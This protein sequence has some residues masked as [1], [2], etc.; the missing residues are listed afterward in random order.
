MLKRKTQLAKPVVISDGRFEERVKNLTNKKKLTRSEAETA[1]RT[2][3]REKEGGPVIRATADGQAY[4]EQ[5][6]IRFSVDAHD[7]NNVVGAN[8]GDNVIDKMM[9]SQVASLAIANGFPVSPFSRELLRPV[10]TGIVQLTWYRDLE[11]YTSAHLEENQ[12][13]RVQLYLDKL[14]TYKQEPEVSNDAPKRIRKANPAR[15]TRRFKASPG[16][17]KGKLDAGREQALYGVLR[18]LKESTNFADIVKA[19]EGKVETKQPLEKI[20]DRFLGKLLAK[21][22]ITAE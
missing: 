13:K 6:D 14:K 12:E 21:G 17:D 10:L 15:F 7:L 9:D 1:V 2:V 16:F 18:A 3:I 5:A 11:N 22:A 4:F 8:R 20:V 19:A